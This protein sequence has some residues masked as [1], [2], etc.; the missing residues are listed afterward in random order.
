MQVNKPIHQ[1]QLSFEGEWPTSVVFLDDNRLAAGNRGGGIFVWD[2]T[3]SPAEP[4]EEAKKSKTP[5]NVFPDRSS[6]RATQ[7]GSRICS[8]RRTARR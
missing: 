8:A 1:W 4:S 3:R 5:P 7:T 6:G 2:L